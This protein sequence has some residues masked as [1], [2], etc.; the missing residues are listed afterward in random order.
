[1]QRDWGAP[2]YLTHSADGTHVCTGLLPCCRLK[3]SRH[4]SIDLN[5]K[6]NILFASLFFRTIH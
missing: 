6:E 5:N 3:Y 2:F 4:C 1:M